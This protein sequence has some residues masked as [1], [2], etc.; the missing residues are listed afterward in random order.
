MA[1]PAT[2]IL[3]EYPTN[4]TTLLYRASDG[5]ALAC[6]LQTKVLDGEDP[7]PATLRTRNYLDVTFARAALRNIADADCVARLGDG[8]AASF[9]ERN[10][11]SRIVAPNS[12]VLGFKAN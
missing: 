1:K 6:R 7:N 4:D 8:Y 11:E 3:L 12:Q 9:E 10:G 2:H 5:C